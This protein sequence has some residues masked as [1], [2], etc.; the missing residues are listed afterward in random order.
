MPYYGIHVK[1]QVDFLTDHFHINS[2]LY[3][4]NSYKH[5]KFEYVK[6]IFKIRS[7]LKKRNFDVIHIH[8]GLSG[9][10][11]LFFK[12][13]AKI[14]LTLHGGD[15]MK[16]QGLFIQN[17]L[18]RLI[19]KRVNKV[20]VLNEEMEMIAKKLGVAYELIP[21]GINTDFFKHSPSKHHSKTTKLVLFPGD[22]SR[23]EK[24]Y[25]LF[26]EVM[27]IIQQRSSYEIRSECIHDLSRI[28]VRNI[29]RSAHCLLMTSTSEGSPQIIKEALS[30]GLPVVSVNVGDVKKVLEDIPSCSISTTRDPSELAQLVLE[31]L[32]SDEIS[33]RNAFLSKGLYDNQT[34][35]QRLIENYTD[36]EL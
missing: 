1:E 28:E 4:I 24:N 22:P 9:L 21:C 26:Q 19:M 15:I 5:G 30:C 17:I 6:S 2:S 31:S 25:P 36:D 13:K 18:S 20:F 10:F 11:L 16:N 27:A 33:I 32:S 35:C 23:K 7:I 29:L 12:P 34:I 14:F 8:Y 3:F